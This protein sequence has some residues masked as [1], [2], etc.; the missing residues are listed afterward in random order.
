MS[1]LLLAAG[2]L[3][4]LFLSRRTT[5]CL[6]LFSCRPADL[7]VSSAPTTVP[8]SLSGCRPPDLSVS[9]A[10]NDRT[11]VLVW[12]SPG[13]SSVSSAPTTVP[14]SLSSCQPA[15]LP[16]LA[17]Q[18]RY[19]CL[20]LAAAKP[21]YPSLP[22]RTT[23]SLSSSSS[24]GGPMIPSLSSGRERG[25]R[26]GERAPTAGWPG[27]GRRGARRGGHHLYSEQHL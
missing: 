15:D 26:R 21:I 17:R 18:V 16:S 19:L 10:P 1:V 22:H 4:Y 6:S 12:L 3:I 11:S 14:L 23:A 9:A 7:S 27:A 24:S 13:R 20:Y 8:L 5:V 25:T 2:Q